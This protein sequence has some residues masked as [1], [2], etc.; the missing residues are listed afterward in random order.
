MTIF[1]RIEQAPP[2]ELCNICGR[3]EASGPARFDRDPAL[4]YRI[5]ETR[6][7]R[8]ERSCHGTAQRKALARIAELEAWQREIRISVRVGSNLNEAIAIADA[9]KAERRCS[10]C[11]LTAD[12]AA[13]GSCAAMAG[14]SHDWQPT[15]PHQNNSTR[16]NRLD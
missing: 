6:S 4:C 1:E 15:S 16:S 8:A 13:G 9:C 3:P 2:H 14:P 5:A 10:R 11:G 12:E 7:R